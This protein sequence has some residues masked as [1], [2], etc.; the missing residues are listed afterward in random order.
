MRFTL[1]AT[2]SGLGSAFDR[3]H[4]LTTNSPL[5]EPPTNTEPQHKPDTTDLQKLT[6]QTG[7]TPNHSTKLSDVRY[8]Q[9]LTQPPAPSS[10]VTARAQPLRMLRNRSNGFPQKPPRGD[11]GLLRYPSP[12][13]PQ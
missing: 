9:L 6:Q 4:Q 2:A 5:T 10:P 13:A 12:D 11:S 1:T 8:S 3:P 7:S